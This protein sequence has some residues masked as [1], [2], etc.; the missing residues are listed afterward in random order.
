MAVHEH[1][2]ESA[3]TPEKIWS[4][5]SNTDTWSSWNPD[6]KSITLDG[7]FADGVT[8]TMVTGSGTRAIRIERVVA[9]SSFDLVTS[10]LPASTFRFHCA[11]RPSGAGSRV[12][13][14]VE[15]AGPLGSI[16]STFMGKRIAQSFDPIL[17]GLVSYAEA[18]GS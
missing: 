6:V 2:V 15:M 14:S 13:Q 8:G 1:A 7:P 10:P 18:S 11:I 9:G 5:W 12:S 16:M 17:N 4:V 3:V